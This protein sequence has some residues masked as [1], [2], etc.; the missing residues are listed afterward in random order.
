MI[1]IIYIYL[2]A[3]VINIFKITL[4]IGLTLTLEIELESQFDYLMTVFRNLLF[5]LFNYKLLGFI[6]VCHRVH[7]HV[8]S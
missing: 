5:C 3:W 1:L 2:I 4:F 7:F 6:L 8:K